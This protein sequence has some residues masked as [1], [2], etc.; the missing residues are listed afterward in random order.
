MPADVAVTREILERC[1]ALGFALAGVASVE[2]TRYESELRAWLGA[3]RHGE[4]DYLARYADLLVDPAGLLD[5]AQSIICVAD[6]YALGTPDAARD[7]GGAEGVSAVGRIARYARGDDYHR[8][9]KRRL[10]ELCDELRARFPAASF[11]AC[12]DTAPLLEREYAARAGL[13]AIG[14]HTLL[15]E[16][17]IG[18]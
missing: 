13:G 15:I 4:M 9:I 1:R 17:G 7:E 12:V 14:K 6:R 11:L 18:S 16:C 10:H 8:V 2:P 5:G 3:G